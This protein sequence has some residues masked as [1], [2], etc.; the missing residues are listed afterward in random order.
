[1]KNNSFEEIG[2]IIRKAEKILLFPHI[3]MDGD[4]LG[5]CAALC[6][7]LR[8]LGK[9]CY[10]L[11]EDHIPANLAFLDR[12]Y[13]TSDQNIVEKPDLSICIDCG[14]ADRFIRRKEK[15]QQSPIT[16]CIDH[17]GTTEFYC[18]YNYV[19]SKAAATGELIF[20]LLRAMDLPLDREM[21]GAIF[22]AITT[23]TGNFQY[24]NTSKETHEITAALYDT[25]IDSN[26]ISVELYENNR[27]EKLLIKNRALN[28]LTTVCDG[29]GV[30]AY[31]TQEMLTETG[32]LM[33]ETE[34]V[35]EELR[36]ISNVEVAA[37][38]KEAEA[39]KIKVSMRSKYKVNVADI[40]YSLGGGG[41]ER[42]AGFT[43]Y[44]SL[45]EAFD[46]ITEK[47]TDSLG[48]L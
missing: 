23:D 35:V 46:M 43:L 28:T 36:S 40:A 44:C 16:I 24:S 29:Q 4:T 27:I 21:G 13:C 12:G 25:G 37:F 33:D 14:D 1:M 30:I 42:A 15:F 41:H 45:T 39:D 5:S 38:L 34:G 32:A 11:I 22:A 48:K 26:E 18:D 3:N 47:M 10:I 6:K 2:N 31:V 17:H 9:E 7:A 8:N 20:K 19:D